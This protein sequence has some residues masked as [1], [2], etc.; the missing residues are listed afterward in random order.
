MQ[1]ERR[2]RL[3]RRR[4]GGQSL[5]VQRHKVACNYENNPQLTNLL[6][7]VQILRTCTSASKE[8]HIDCMISAHVP[9]L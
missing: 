8:K 9:H 4:E 7:Q 6:V 2:G 3:D 1:G 5:R